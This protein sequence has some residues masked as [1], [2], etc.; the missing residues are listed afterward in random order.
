MLRLF[1]LLSALLAGPALGAASPAVETSTL[2][3]RVVSAS[4]GVGEGSATLA[5]GL[6]L[7]LAAGWKT[8]WRSPGEVGLPPDLSWDGS[9]NVADVALDYPAPT[10]F[11]AFEIENFGYADEVV[12]PLTVTLAEPGAAARLDLR[13]DLLVCAEICVPETVEIVL[14]LPAGGGVDAAGAALLSDWVAR[15][16]VPG[17]EAGLRIER[18]HLGSEALTL[19]IRADRPMAIPDIFPEQGPYAAF[20]KPDL[21]LGEGGHLLWARLPVLSPGEAP[22]DVT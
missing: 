20:G 4:D 18:A 1:L 21:R 11:T 14:D 5:A 22:L 15:V 2:S 19:A 6:H 13:A 16:P 9:V 10:R 3:A 7:T 17:A 8:Y 12:F